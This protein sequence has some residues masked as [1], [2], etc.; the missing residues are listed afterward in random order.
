MPVRVDDEYA[1]RVSAIRDALSWHGAKSAAA[2]YL[3]CHLSEVT[4]WLAITIVM[5]GERL[6]ILERFCRLSRAEQESY[7]ARTT[8]QPPDHNTP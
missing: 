3:N 7:L 8:D 2:R 5:S 1:A 4:R 6:V